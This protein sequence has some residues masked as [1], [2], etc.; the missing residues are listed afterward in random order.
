[1][2]ISSGLEKV[3][4]GINRIL[5]NAGHFLSFVVVAASLMNKNQRVKATQSQTKY[6]WD[7]GNK[8]IAFDLITM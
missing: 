5:W 3:L 7:A 4:C 2:Q 6:G 8:S 1:M